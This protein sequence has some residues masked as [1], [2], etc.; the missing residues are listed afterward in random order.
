ME[1]SGERT[2]KLACVGMNWK[3]QLGLHEEMSE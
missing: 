3:L 1:A 2:G